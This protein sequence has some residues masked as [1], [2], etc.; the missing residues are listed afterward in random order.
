MASCSV[1]G[2]LKGLAIFTR[3]DVKDIS[4]NKSTPPSCHFFVLS[5]M[6]GNLTTGERSVYKDI[7]HL[8]ISLSSAHAVL[9]SVP[10]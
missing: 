7:A 8:R 4:R 5:G 9:K 2:F 10:D 1:A 3:G 6:Q